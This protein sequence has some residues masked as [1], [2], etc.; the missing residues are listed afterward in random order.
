M[1]SIVESSS[2][3]D[4]SSTAFAPQGACQALV[5][6]FFFLGDFESVR[7]YALRGVQIWRSG[8]VHSPVEQVDPPAV[9]CLCYKALAEV[10]FEDIASSQSTI[11]E[12]ISLAKELNDEHALAEALFFAASLRYSPAETERLASELIELSARHNFAHWLPLANIFRGWARSA[13]GSPAEGIVWIEDGLRDYRA[14]GSVLSLTCY[15]GMKAEAL[16]IADRTREALEVTREAQAVGE[17]T[18]ERFWCA[19]LHRLSGVFLT[20]LSADKTQI[21][22]S[23]YEA[24]RIAKEQKSV[25]LEQRAEET[26]AE[27][28]RKKAS[29]AGGRGFR[30]SL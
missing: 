27:Y 25:F 29:A 26:Y 15:L 18:D 28:R 14:T 10:F 13:A 20:A 21:E 24:I 7:Q 8:G 12:A 22:A 9:V 16:Y 4:A 6:T 5:S 1:A 30:L 19:E 17:K 23:F 3:A 11:A 2:N